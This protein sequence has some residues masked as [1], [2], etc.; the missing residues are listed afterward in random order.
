MNFRISGAIA[1]VALLAGACTDSRLIDD[2]SGMKPKESGFKANLHSQY[3]ALAN[4]ELSEGDFYDSGVFA[5][6][7]EAA[8]MGQ[9][10]DPDILWDRHYSSD[11]LDT[12]IGERSRLT[13]AL[14]GGGRERFAELAATAQTQFDCWAQ[15][16]EENH[17]PEDIRKCREGYEVAIKSLE[18][19]LKPKQVAKKPVP[20]KPAPTP[21]PTP[22]IVRDYLLFFDF[23]SDSLTD[24][25][26][27]I[28]RA[29]ADAG[30][31]ASVS[32][33]EV[34][35]HA[36]RSGPDNYNLGLSER[37]AAAVQAELVLLGVE[38]GEVVVS[39]KGEREPLVETTDGIREPQNR[40]VEILLK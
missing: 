15:E 39:W 26:K 6:R 22:Q 8:A 10:V 25:A 29:A 1:A 24:S 3:I 14:D 40:R 31:N 9:E 7:A 13:D 35:G 23:D 36:D 18:D 20:P 11:N 38:A 32:A 21:A 5:R 33:I 2:V 16:L 37:R 19:G 12:L 30:R 17:Q 34:T 4:V 28:I 27:A